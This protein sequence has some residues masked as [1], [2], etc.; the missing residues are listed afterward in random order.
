[1]KGS[2]F[3]RDFMN[4]DRVSKQAYMAQALSLTLEKRGVQP[5]AGSADYAGVPKQKAF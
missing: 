3:W 2:I 1:M 4:G 5:I